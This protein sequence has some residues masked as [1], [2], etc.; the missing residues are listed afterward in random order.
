M[1]SVLSL[2]ECLGSDGKVKVASA[3]AQFKTRAAYPRGAGAG[4][5]TRWSTVAGSGARGK[6][7]RR[8]VVVIDHYP[9]LDP[10]RIE[11]TV[12]LRIRDT[13]EALVQEELTAALGGLNSARVGDLRQVSALDAGP[14]TDHDPRPDDDRDPAR[15]G[16]G[17][18]RDEPRTAQ[19]DGAPVRARYPAR[20]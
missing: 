1:A 15:Q 5:M 20:R 19:Q 6:R 16:A 3:P 2:R 4:R 18:R 12:R 11:M 14:G 17:G 10:D 13:V 8:W 9:A 7:P